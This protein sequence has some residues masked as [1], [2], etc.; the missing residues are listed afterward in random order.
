M[1]IAAT[2]MSAGSRATLRPLS[3]AYFES[4][5]DPTLRL[6][7]RRIERD[8]AIQPI[9]VGRRPVSRTRTLPG[10]RRA[11]PHRRQMEH[12]HDHDPRDATAAL[13]RASPSHPRHLQA[14][15]HPDA[16]RLGARRTYYPACLS[17]QAAA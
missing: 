7:E 4:W 17:D 10:A 1:T 13:Q 3:D 8:R 15:A 2:S 9:S 11:R 16:A 5:S 14:H 12:T 6:Y